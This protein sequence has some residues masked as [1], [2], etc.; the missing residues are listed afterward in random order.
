[1]RNHFGRVSA[2]SD[3]SISN[4]YD[5]STNGSMTVPRRTLSKSAS[6]GSIRQRDRW[7][8]VNHAFCNAKDWLSTELIVNYPIQEVW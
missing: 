5:F 1:M 6:Q 4:F 7:E 2:P 8:T 3:Q